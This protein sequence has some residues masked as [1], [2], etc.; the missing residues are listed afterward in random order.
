MTF[1]TE[2]YFFSNTD[3]LKIFSTQPEL[4]PYSFCVQDGQNVEVITQVGVAAGKDDAPYELRVVDSSGN[5][6]GTSTA[7]Y[8]LNLK[9]QLTL[10]WKGTINLPDGIDSDELSVSL[11]KIY[12][13]GQKQ[14]QQDADEIAA[15]CWTASV[16]VYDSP[17]DVDSSVAQCS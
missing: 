12:E 7:E 3:I 11:I 17:V 16:T 4:K 1:V 6:L 8:K 10:S 5:V 15:G 9:E 13:N 14:R 2:E